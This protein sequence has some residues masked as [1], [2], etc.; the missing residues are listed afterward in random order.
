[1]ITLCIHHK[2]TY[3][4]REPV[5][6]LPHRLMLFLRALQIGALVAA[7]ALQILLCVVEFVLLER[8]LGVGQ[9]QPVRVLGELRNALL[10]EAVR[11]PSGLMRRLQALTKETIP[12]G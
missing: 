12:C 9:F 10:A 3:R 7:F 2:T 6:L 5:S 4:Y 11:D 1:M 8:Q